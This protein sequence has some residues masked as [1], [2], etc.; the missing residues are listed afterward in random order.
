MRCAKSC[1]SPFSRLSNSSSSRCVLGKPLRRR[2]TCV[3]TYVRRFINSEALCPCKFPAC[4]TSA[5]CK[6]SKCD[7]YRIRSTT[8]AV[9][10]AVVTSA[11]STA[12]AY[13]NHYQ[14]QYQQW[15]TAD[16]LEQRFTNDNINI[17]TITIRAS[18]YYYGVS[19]AILLS[20]PPLILYMIDGTSMCSK[21]LA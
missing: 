3:H 16:D 6:T 10:A 12:A 5:V 20:L 19:A 2:V 14:H 1:M 9:I 8:I 7:C 21:L 4:T 18:S 17:N 11:C 15:C 13:N